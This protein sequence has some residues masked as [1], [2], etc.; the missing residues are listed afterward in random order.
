L[1][2]YREV[3]PGVFRV[4]YRSGEELAPALQSPLIAAVEAAARGGRTAVAFV[5]EPGIRTVPLDVP[6]FWLNVTARNDLGLVAFAII[7]RSAGVRVAAK[8]FGLANQLRRVSLEVRTFDE[9][10]DG[11][12]WLRG[13]VDRKAS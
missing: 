1:S 12:A 8:G 6:T 11:L 10:A 2:N 9:E 13:A 3:A 7:T 5:L 4:H